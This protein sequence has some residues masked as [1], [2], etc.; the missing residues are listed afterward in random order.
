MYVLIYWVWLIYK[1]YGRIKK[2]NVCFYNFIGNK[3]ILDI[4]FKF[5]GINIRDEFLKF[6]FKYY[7]FN[8]ML[9]V[10]LGKGELR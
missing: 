7:F 2:W 5:K 3:D 4:I 1:E 10:V 9:L 8:I 6:Y